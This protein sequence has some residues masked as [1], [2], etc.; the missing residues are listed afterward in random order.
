[1]SPV[2]HGDTGPQPCPDLREIEP[3]PVLF[4]YAVIGDPDHVSHIDAHGSPVVQDE[5]TERVLG[6][7]AHPSCFEPQTGQGI[8]HVVFSTPDPDLKLP[9]EFQTAVPSRAQPNHAFTQT[10]HIQLTGC[11]ISNRKGH[12]RIS[13]FFCCSPNPYASDR[14]RNAEVLSQLAKKRDVFLSDGTPL[15]LS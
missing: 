4:A 9:G 11:L 7:F 13:S 5:T 15:L 6:E 14:K 1:M 2:I 3:H 12:G 10:H 8:G